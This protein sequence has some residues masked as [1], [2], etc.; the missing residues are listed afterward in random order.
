MRHLFLTFAMLGAAASAWSQPLSESGV[1]IGHDYSNP[2]QERAR[3]AVKR[4]LPSRRYALPAVSET[5][6]APLSAAEVERLKPRVFSEAQPWK[7]PVGV[8]RGVGV[9]A[10]EQGRWTTTDDGR[11]VYRFLL[12]SPGAAAVRFHFT[13]FAVGSGRVWIHDGQGSENEI[14]GPYTGGGPYQDGEF[15]SDSVFSETAM[16]EFEPAA[17][18]LTPAAGALTED[19]PFAIR[20]IAH[21]SDD[22]LVSPETKGK[23]QAAVSCHR[24]ASCHPQWDQ[25]SRAVARMLYEEDGASYNCSGTLLTSRAAGN[26]PYFLTADHCISNNSVARTLQT[27]W[28]FQT[29]SCN[30]TPPDVRT[31]PR[32]LGSTYLSGIAFER[33]DATLLRLNEI[34]SGVFFSGYQT[35]EVA[36]GPDG[37]GLHHPSGSHKRISFGVLR[38]GYPYSGITQSA[39]IGHF[40]NGGGLT[41]P[42]SSGSG[43]FLRPGVVAGMLSHGPK[44]EENQ[45][46]GALPF[47][48]NY[49]RFSLFYPQIRTFLE[50]DG[51]GGG[52]G[53]TGGGPSLNARTLA[54]GQSVSFSLPAVQQPTLMAGD[55]VFQITVPQGS[56]RLDIQL[57][58]SANTA[59]LG[60]Y[61]R[62][63]TAPE[64]AA[65]AVVADHASEGNGSRTLSI[66]TT[67]SPALRPGVYIIRIAVFTPNLTIPASITATVSNSIGG[68][69]P[70][71]GGGGGGTPSRTLTHNNSATFN[72]GGFNQTAI[73]NGTNG[74]LVVVPPNT[75]SLTVRLSTSAPSRNYDVD[76]Y[77]R[78]AQDISVA[79]NRPV[80]DYFSEGDFGEEE[81][82]ATS[83]SRPPLQNGTY[84]IGLIVRPTAQFI[85]LPVTVTLTVL[86]DPAPGGGGSA[87]PQNRTLVSGQ[88]AAFAFTGQSAPTLY[89]GTNSFVITVPQGA[90]RMEIRLNTTTPNVDVDLYARAGQDVV[91]FNRQI[92]A[93]YRSE[94]PDGSE[95]IVITSASRPQLQSGIYY[96]TLLVYDT[97]VAVQG[98]LTATIT[99]GTGGGGG[100]APGGGGTGATALVS[101]QA[102]TVS[103]G[104][105]ST[106]TLYNGTA[107]YTVTVPANASRLEITLQ[108]DSSADVDL[109]AR[110]GADVAIEGNRIFSDASSINRDS[111]EQIVISGSALRPG[112]Y[113][114]AMVLYTTGVPVQASLRATVFTGGAGSGGSTPPP[115]TQELT[116]GRPASYSLPPVER[117]TLFTGDYSFILRVPEGATRVDFNMRG[118]GSTD[119]DLYVRRGADVDL[120]DGRI[121]ADYSSEGPAGTETISITPNSDPALQPGIYY[122]S[123]V[124]WDTNTAASGTLT[125]T[126]VQGT[127]G[128]T[129]P[130]GP[131]PLIPGAPLKFELPA[132]DSP[133]LFNGN[134]SFR[135]TVPAGATQLS[136]RL[137]SDFPQV[138][139][140]LFVRFETDNDVVGG[141]VFTDHSAVTDRAN[142]TVTI[143]PQ[144]QPALRAGTYWVSVG[145]YTTGLPT[146][147]TLTAT[148]QR[149]GFTTSSAEPTP[150]AHVPGKAGGVGAKVTAAEA[151]A[152]YKARDAE[153]GVTLKKGRRAWNASP[154]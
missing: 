24:D 34:P 33:G 125:A 129:A 113:F 32:R 112:T 1:V 137:A 38:A 86:L 109:F 89:N 26:I 2:E 142:E 110:N 146:S 21:L 52:G 134:Y 83:N 115:Q 29:P 154:Q 30:G 150:L 105:V 91:L 111:N 12:R 16:L 92:Q 122:V 7:Q 48:V 136:V 153:L 93:D 17:G 130:D 117:P 67:G 74:F 5:S 124:L 69:T 47:T 87:A 9:K 75:R 114:I 132:V 51:P 59:Q 23:N 15:W 61:A 128:G 18:A 63:G 143:T 43:I 58:T 60:L 107:G 54:S 101:G 119:V 84:F 127:G 141:E 66:T 147:G 56:A 46:C 71:G 96:I 135:V 77:V 79:N 78:Y 25:T 98:S 104:P 90:T 140:D 39:F 70:G 27:F 3:E 126:V 20:E 102:R 88:P 95:T 138:D 53:G 13:G 148:V 100:T 73:V 57:Q 22:F 72:L 55:A 8:H 64:V 103:L 37:T 108:S 145:V 151:P 121:V 116:S 41:Q 97:N 36:S 118:V 85:N 94:G 68:G 4:M 80:A 6:L 76:L 139:T 120:A 81:I 152:V 14:A 123:L 44:L 45:Y 19:L 106:P 99:G 149:G 65:G 144:S 10:A 11:R 133:T 50:G 28:F 49:G 82:T 35:T 62:F 42:G 40:L 131:R 31:V